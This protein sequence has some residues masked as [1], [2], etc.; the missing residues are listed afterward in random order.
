MA[1]YQLTRDIPEKLKDARPD[2]L[3]LEEKIQIELGLVELESDKT[4]ENAWS[5]RESIEWT[6]CMALH[7]HETLSYNSHRYLPL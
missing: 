3:Q 2:P 4:T 5:R 7:H 1:G 6:L